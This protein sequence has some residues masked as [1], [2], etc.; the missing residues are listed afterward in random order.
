M[1]TVHCEKHGKDYFPTDGFQKEG[2]S[3]KGIATNLNIC[4]FNW[5]V[6]K[7]LV[8]KLKDYS[9]SYNHIRFFLHFIS[10]F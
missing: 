2:S 9:V 6:M 1:G 4:F 10:N 8:E 5:F 7:D 3:E